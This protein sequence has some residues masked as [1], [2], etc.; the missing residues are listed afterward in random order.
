MDRARIQQLLGQA[1]PAAS[2]T[3]FASG[4][5]AEIPV[6]PTHVGIA[7]RINRHVADGYE[8]L[9]A[10]SWAEPAL[11]A[12]VVIYT[13]AALI[14]VVLVTVSSRGDADAQTSTFAV[15][16][17]LVSTIAG[18]ACIG[19]G[20]L[21]LR[22]SRLAAYRWFMRGLLVWILVTQ[23]FVF[24]SSQLAGL[25]GLLFDLIAYGSVRLATTLESAAR[26][27]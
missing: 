6:A 26:P 25:G 2:V 19:I 1:D 18:A 12:G 23:V 15:T 16:A 13:V 8:R 7:S 14:G 27:G 24:Y 5:L 3:R 4:Y 22:E 17:Q 9:M 21:R 10:N 11:I 20:V